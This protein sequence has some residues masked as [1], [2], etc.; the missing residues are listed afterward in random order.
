MKK[1]ETFSKFFN[2]YKRKA[3]FQCRTCF[4]SRVSKALFLICILY[5]DTFLRTLIKAEPTIE[6]S[7]N[8]YDSLNIP[9][10]ENFNV[11][12]GY[13]LELLGFDLSKKVIFS[14]SF[15]GFDINRTF[16]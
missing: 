6:N 13:V 1:H 8:T 2:S 14:C 3:K 9:Q 16:H 10:R 11:V 5:F 4:P 12:A 7:A 15:A